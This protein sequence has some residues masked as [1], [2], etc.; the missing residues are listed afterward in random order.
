MVALVGAGV[1]FASLMWLLW[2]DS[3][4]AEEVYVGDLASV[5]GKQTEQIILD[6]RD[7]L[8][9]FDRMTLARCSDEHLKALQDAAIARPHI[10]AIGYW[11]DRA[12]LSTRVR[13]ISPSAERRRGSL[14]FREQPNRR[15]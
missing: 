9:T 4:G 13:S 6:T 10:R 15:G 12:T 3:L 8:E 7:M 2:K 5:L 1:L 11:R 14:V